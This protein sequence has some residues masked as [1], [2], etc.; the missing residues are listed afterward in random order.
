MFHHPDWAV[1]S[2][3][4]CPP[5]WELS[6]Y[7]STQPRS[8]TFLGHEVTLYCI[9]FQKRK[10]RALSSQRVYRTLSS[11]RIKV[12]H[13]GGSGGRRDASLPTLMMLRLRHHTEREGGREG[14]RERDY[15]HVRLPLAGKTSRD[16]GLPEA[17]KMEKQVAASPRLRSPTETD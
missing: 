5:A 4:C 13:G 3:S 11:H 1:G 10:I 17:E 8:E 2:Y 15:L 6:K 12:A 14:G 9:E 7:K 16:R